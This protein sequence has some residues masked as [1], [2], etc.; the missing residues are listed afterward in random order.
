MNSTLVLK[1]EGKSN[2]LRIWGIFTV[3]LS[4]L[5]IPS[6]CQSQEVTITDVSWENNQATLSW[7]GGAPPFQLQ[8]SSNL[9]GWETVSNPTDLSEISLQTDQSLRFYRVLSASNNPTLGPYIGQLRVAEGEFGTPLARHR[10][11]SLWSFYSPE[12]SAEE[13][14]ALGFFSTAIVKLEILEGVERTEI[15]APLDAFPNGT[16]THS[17]RSIRAVWSTGLGEEKRDYTLELSFRFDVN[18][19]RPSI[20]LS[21]PSYKFTCRYAQPQLLI[22]RSGDLGATKNDEVELVEIPENPNAPK[23]WQRHF[24]VSKGD[25]TIDSRYE[26][27]VPN[28]EGGPAFIFKTPLLTQWDRTIVSGL[29]TEPIELTSRFSQSYFPFHHNFVETLYLDPQL[30]PGISDESLAELSEQ[31]IWMIVPTQPTAFPN[32]ES[33]LQV[34]GFDNLLRDL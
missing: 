28:I 30:E 20:H 10:L 11:K 19:R 31:N 7:S 22:D 9:T 15:V 13:R 27:G 32:S 3:F 6:I 4:C 1:A 24:V 5:L 25:V 17:D 14:T 34:L 21:D 18:Q 2:R 23:W 26:I 16:M 33:T 8:Q 29:T 12:G